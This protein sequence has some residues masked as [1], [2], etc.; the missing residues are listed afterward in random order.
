MTLLFVC[1]GPRKQAAVDRGIQDDISLPPPLLPQIVHTSP[2]LLRNE[3]QSIQ[4][5]PPR[6][7]LN[8]DEVS[9]IC[10]DSLPNFLQE[11]SLMD[12][13]PTEELL[14]TPL[15]PVSTV[16]PS[17]TPEPFQPLLSNYIG[18]SAQSFSIPSISCSTAETESPSPLH[19]LTSPLPL[20]SS[21]NPQSPFPLHQPSSPASFTTSSISSP[22][23]S[24]SLSSSPIPDPDT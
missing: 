4:T 2:S 17:S 8:L 18:F 9:Q 23:L 24:P 6:E 16:S 13:T 22:D 10:S 7:I 11:R 5:S 3:L 15:L 14:P 1:R 20:L 12:E 19:Q 21:T